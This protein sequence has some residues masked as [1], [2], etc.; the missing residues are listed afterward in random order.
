LNTQLLAAFHG[1]NPSWFA[2]V[3]QF[4]SLDPASWWFFVRD[5]RITER[6]LAR[7]RAG[8]LPLPWATFQGHRQP[9]VDAAEQ[10][11]LPVTPFLG[12][13]KAWN[14]PF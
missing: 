8:M 6:V 9:R 3:R 11:L 7:L 4:L 12:L 14:V 13:S 10:P 1:L 5:S 2:L